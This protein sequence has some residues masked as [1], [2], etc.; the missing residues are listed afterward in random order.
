M[1][2]AGTNIFIN[3]GYNEYSFGDPLIKYYR[4]TTYSSQ[5]CDVDVGP[6]GEINL[7]DLQTGR[8][9]QYDDEC[10]LM[11]I[12]GGSGDQ[13][14][15]FTT[16]NAVESIGTDVYVLD[17]RKSTITV[18]KRTEFGSIAVSYTHLRAHET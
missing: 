7:L 16:V 1:N 4:G 9:F 13:K 11:F 3:L 14:G 10:T 18:F 15:T 17:S 2:S 5:I 8:V 6:N 12:F